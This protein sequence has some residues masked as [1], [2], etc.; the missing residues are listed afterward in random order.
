MNKPVNR[1]ENSMT[2]PLQNL[3]TII[4]RLPQGLQDH[5]HRVRDTALELASLHSVD[6]SKVELA[7]L[8]HDIYRAYQGERL[9]EEARILGLD[10]HPVAERVPILLHGPLAAAHL[11]RDCDITD[12]EI[13]EAV[14]W[15]T[16]SRPGMG[17]VGLV[18]FLADKVEPQK[19]QRNPY[20]LEVAETARESLERAA[21]DYLTAEIASLLERR[22]L[23]HP[24][25]IE[26]RNDL[27]M[28]LD[29]SSPST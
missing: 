3:H 17:G 28:R 23:L 7:A 2:S 6:A 9:L 10:M 21:L 1:T 8:G 15:H 20:L 13:L 14:R 12:P 19:A 5:L 24:A 25:S 22:S 4:Q 18:V 27:L 26:A 16:T 11:E 29:D